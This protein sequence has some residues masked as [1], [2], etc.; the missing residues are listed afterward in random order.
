MATSLLKLASCGN[1]NAAPR[2]ASPT[3]WLATPVRSATRVAARPGRAGRWR[4]LQVHGDRGVASIMPRAVTINSRVLRRLAPRNS[5]VLIQLSIGHREQSCQRSWR[6]RIE[7]RHTNRRFKHVSVSGEDI[8]T[9][10]LRQL[11]LEAG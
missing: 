6:F 7:S 2:I 10:L 11:G 5:L 3:I 4:A 1:W 8:A 9:V